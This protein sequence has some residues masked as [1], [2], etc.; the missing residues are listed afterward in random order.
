MRREDTDTTTT[1][2]RYLRLAAGAGV[3]GLA[4]CSSQSGGGDGGAEATDSPTATP[5]ETA[6]D[7]PTE[8][9]TDSPTPTPTPIEYGF[10][11]GTTLRDDRWFVGE[12]DDG[13]ELARAEEFAHSGGFSIGLAGTPLDVLATVQLFGRNEVRG[14]RISR[15]RYHW[16]ETGESFGG[17]VLLLNSDGE[18]ELFTGTDNPQW[19]VLTDED[20]STMPVLY[21]GDGTRR[22]IRTEA[23]FDWDAGTAAVAFEDLETGTTR[24]TAVPLGDG[25]DVAQIRFT[26]FTSKRY[27]DGEGFRSGSC[28]MYWDDILIER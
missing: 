2:R 18:L 14:R 24:E 22:W 21:E 25:T 9:A 16:L 28:H 3:V 10:E 12:H 1:R 23:T 17:G 27:Q 7:S 13:A 15:L 19:M 4:G 8:T 6:T 26:P 5:T 11:T 20:P